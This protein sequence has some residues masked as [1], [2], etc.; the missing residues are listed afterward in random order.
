ML[1]SGRDAEAAD[2]A[3]G[4]V[5]DDVAVEVGQHE[6]VELLRPLDEPHAERVDEILA[7]LD[8]GVVAR[9]LA[10]DGEEEPVR[11]LHDVRLRACSALP[12][13]RAAARTRRRS[14]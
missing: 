9:D 6:D 3:G 4:Q 14:G 13:G 7:R 10:E 5:A 12:C 2:E 11:V 1:A 8:V